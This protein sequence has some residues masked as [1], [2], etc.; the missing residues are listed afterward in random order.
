MPRILLLFG[1]AALASALYL[2]FTPPGVSDECVDLPAVIAAEETSEQVIEIST[3]GDRTP[4][5]QEVDTPETP[6][7]LAWYEDENFLE[8]ARLEYPSHLALVQNRVAMYASRSR[9]V[10]GIERSL[11]QGASLYMSEEFSLT[12]DELVGSSELGNVDM[13]N[14]LSVMAVGRRETGRWLADL[15]P[16]KRD[17]AIKAMNDRPLDFPPSIVM[18]AYLSDERPELKPDFVS[19]AKALYLETL[20]KLNAAKRTSGIG[21]SATIDTLN[22]LGVELPPS[23]EDLFAGFGDLSPEYQS[24]TTEEGMISNLYLIEFRALVQKH[25][26]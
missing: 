26:Q 4:S 11:E 19:D 25:Y 10:A 17:W 3:E 23:S 9:G 6:P 13:A 20:P 22:S 8:R 14:A 18:Q 21:A 15:E 1:A 24:G 7:D 16:F 5:T 12:Q 2:L